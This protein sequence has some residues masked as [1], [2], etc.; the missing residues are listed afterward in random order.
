MR[1][2]PIRGPQCLAAATKATTGSACIIREDLPRNK[3]CKV[4]GAPPHRRMERGEHFGKI[5]LSV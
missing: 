5:V 1:T 2:A 4:N 3:G